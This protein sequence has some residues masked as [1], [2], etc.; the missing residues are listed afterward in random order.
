[1]SK[2]FLC[3]GKELNLVKNFE[4]KNEALTSNVAIFTKMFVLFQNGIGLSKGQRA[5][6]TTS[7]RIDLR[8]L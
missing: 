5:N 4:T 8:I 7:A 3:T 2:P 1:M 6:K